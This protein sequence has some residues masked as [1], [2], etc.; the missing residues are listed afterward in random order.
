M[1]KAPL[2]EPGAYPV[3]YRMNLFQIQMNMWNLSD[4]S[5]SMSLNFFGVF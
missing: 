3:Q 4:L 1:I 2:S 5:S